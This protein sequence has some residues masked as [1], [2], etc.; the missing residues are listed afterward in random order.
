MNNFIGYYYR[1]FKRLQ[2]RHSSFIEILLNFLLWKYPL[3]KNIIYCT[4]RIIKLPLNNDVIIRRC[5]DISEL[6][7]NELSAINNYLGEKFYEQYVA[8]FDDGAELWLGTKA[9]SLAGA[10]WSH[11]HKKET[12]HFYVPL[13]ATDARI[14][15][16]YVLPEHRG[17]SIY[18]KMIREI[19]NTL[20]SENAGKV[21]IDCKS[22]NHPSVR[23]IQK[24]GFK[25][26]GSAW[27]FKI[28]SA[29]WAFMNN[30]PTNK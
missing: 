21:F 4:D 14:L 28:G 22:W 15:F 25:L 10:C 9:G 1:H 30:C 27:E 20:I 5:H 26:Y 19:S 12:D 3:Y 7:D 8:L 11:W 6:N 24:A 17:Q 2:S 13:K 16:C 23:G 18:P 29:R